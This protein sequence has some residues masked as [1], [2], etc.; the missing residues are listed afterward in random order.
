MRARLIRH[1]DRVDQDGGQILILMLFYSLIA[2]SLVL[3]GIDVSMAYLAR[4]DL[5]NVADG[6]ALAGAE[7][8]DAATFYDRGASGY[9]PVTTSSAQ[10]GVTDYLIRTG[11]LR[12]WPD[13]EPIVNVSGHTVTV[14]L[15][16]KVHLPLVSVL[17]LADSSYADGAVS[18]AATAH[19]ESPLTGG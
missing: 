8:L 2:A 10:Q 15:Q 18:V 19:A 17:G 12:R 7:R 16:R 13:L 1:D 14:T 9:L 6:A 4:R 11:A 3:V 5:A